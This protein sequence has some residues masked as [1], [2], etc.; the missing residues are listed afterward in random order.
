MN[1][2]KIVHAANLAQ[3]K[4]ALETKKAL[5]LQTQIQKKSVQAAKQAAH[6]ADVFKKRVAHATNAADK[7][8]AQ[9]AAMVSHKEAVLAKKAAKAHTKELKKAVVQAKKEARVSK[10]LKNGKTV[11]V[12]PADAPKI[13]ALE[14]SRDA[15]KVQVAGLRAKVNAKKA[16]K[17]PGMKGIGEDVEPY[18]PTIDTSGMPD[19]TAA[20]TVTDPALAAQV[21]VSALPQPGMPAPKGCAKKPNKPICMFYSMAVTSQQQVFALVQEITALQAQLIALINDLRS[22]AFNTGGAAA[23]SADPTVTSGTESDP[24]GMGPGYEQGGGAPT[25]YDPGAAAADDPNAGF[26]EHDAGAQSGGDS[27][28]GLEF[29]T[30]DELDSE[31]GRDFGSG[32]AA[33]TGGG[34]IESEDGP[35]GGGGAEMVSG[36]SNEFSTESQ[37]AAESG[38]EGGSESVEDFGSS[39]QSGGGGFTPASSDMENNFQ[40]AASAEESGAAGDGGEFG[41]TGGAADS[42]YGGGYEGGATSYNPFDAGGGAEM[43]ESS[44]ESPAE[45]GDDFGSG[46][47]Y[48]RGGSGYGGGEESGAEDES[49]IEPVDDGG[50]FTNAPSDS[51][52]EEPETSLTRPDDSAPEDTAG[53]SD[54][55]NGS[56]DDF[57]F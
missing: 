46:G 38:Y 28:G 52:Y 3:K 47:D 51:G 13:T 37:E 23:T 21:Q 20:A 27:G 8:A 29:G 24:Y 40:E 35:G 49:L 57:G 30:Q 56:A 45:A 25:M 1:D 54:F 26:I 36:P 9:W 2:K 12:P 5:H 31:S 53:G 14:N 19:P 11:S 10:K 39:Y 55:E 48:G 50:S 33:D 6:K 42:G 16:A 7:K 34:F 32:G 44:V 22:G 17:K 43:E 15:L 41:N 4:K 18:G